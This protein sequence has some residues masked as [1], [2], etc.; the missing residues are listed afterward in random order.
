ML[1]TA[2]K[3]Q[4]RT[5]Q[6][7]IE[8]LFALSPAAPAFR[9]K[10]SDEAEVLR[11][12]AIEPVQTVVMSSY[13]TDNGI[14]SE[15]NRGAFYGHRASDGSL[16]GVALIGHSTLVEARSEEAMT[17]FAV[18]AQNPEV[19]IHLIMSNG[20]DAQKF[21]DRM[22]NWVG[23]PRLR[24]VEDRFEAA[25]PFAVQ[26]SEYAIRNADMS[27][28]EAVAKAQAELAFIECGVDPIIRDREGFL[29]RVA[30]RIEQGRIFSVFEGGKL[31]FKADIIAETN[32]TIYLEGIYVDPEYRGK[33]IG[34]RCLAAL[35]AHLLS[36]VPNI[37]L[38]SNVD[39]TN[40]HRSYHKAG[41]RRTGQ[42]VT[43]FV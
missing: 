6:N 43:L 4:R 26:S 18:A 41:F 12:L 20:D 17:A 22:T 31:I 11:F 7:A 13:I 21:F 1:N 29:K 32:E 16:D 28:L 15:L 14:E 34:S 37:C 2:M 24:C 9:L 23:T 40:A 35:T 25:F 39:F 8:P 38:L 10:Q 5:A 42:C 27:Q 19:P 3:M 30:R 33:G 36:R